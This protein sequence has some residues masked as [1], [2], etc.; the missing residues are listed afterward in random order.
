MPLQL[1][2]YPVDGGTGLSDDVK[3]ISALQDAPLGEFPINIPVPVQDLVHPAPTPLNLA[4]SDDITQQYWF[5]EESGKSQIDPLLAIR[6]SDLNSCSSSPVGVVAPELSIQSRKSTGSKST[7]PRGV[8]ID[9]IMDVTEPANA[10]GSQQTLAVESNAKRKERTAPF[11]YQPSGDPSI[12][13]VS[14]LSSGP[15]PSQS[16]D[17]CIPSIATQ[18]CYSIQPPQEAAVDTRAT[19]SP[20]KKVRKDFHR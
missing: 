2:C 1:S 9:Q 18:D 6:Q 19:P 7:W 20:L 10:L 5:I 17:I 11:L 16:I 12:M 4:N 15:S 8:S 14:D 3:G 13:S